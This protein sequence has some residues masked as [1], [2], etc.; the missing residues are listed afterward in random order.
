MLFREIADPDGII[1][2]VRRDQY[3]VGGPVLPHAAAEDHILAAL[4][5]LTQEVD[6]PYQRH[7]IV[8]ELRRSGVQYE[9]RAVTNALARLRA[10]MPPRLE[11]ASRGL[12]RLVKE[13]DPRALPPNRR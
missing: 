10:E 5:T 6:R 4:R 8:A 12:Y 13:S 1:R 7:E 2:R 11:R 3:V 9:A